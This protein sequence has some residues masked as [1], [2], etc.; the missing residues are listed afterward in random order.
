MRTFYD[1]IAQ[2]YD[3]ENQHFLDDLPLYIE[4]AEEHGGK[5][6]D[7]GC[8]TGRV[9]FHL[10]SAGYDV[11]GVDYS[12]QM[13][14]IAERKLQASPALRSRVKLVQT[15]ILQYV[16][17]E[18]FPLVLVPYNGLM[19]F[20]E[21][22]D[23]LAVLERLS[24]LMADDGLLVMD[25]PN[26]GEAMATENDGTLILERSFLVDGNLVMQ[27]SV[28]YIDRVQQH[29]SVT[30][31]YDEIGAEDQVLRRT[32]APL[33]LRYITWGEMQL[34]L[35]LA[36]LA[37]VDVYGDYEQNPFEDGAERMIVVAQKIGIA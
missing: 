15:D 18:Q 35:R 23:Q 3:A 29:L 2:Y 26:A 8:G 13:L 12:E 5:I 22:A 27:Q 17:V 28:S 16:S 19:H 25:L 14:A 6:L 4:L 7:V 31:I 11:V 20:P 9:T 24:T 34:L 37:I 10:A 33:A 36:G 30:W 1:K 21:Q 32:L